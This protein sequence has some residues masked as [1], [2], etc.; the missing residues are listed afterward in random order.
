METLKIAFLILTALLSNCSSTTPSKVSP[1]DSV[2][3]GTWE[4]MVSDCIDPKTGSTPEYKDWDPNVHG[5]DRLR[6]KNGEV[7][8]ESDL[9]DKL[10]CVLVSND[11]W[12]I[13]KE[14]YR[15][16]SST[17]IQND[18]FKKLGSPNMVLSNLEYKYEVSED[19][20]RLYWDFARANKKL[21][22]AEKFQCAGIQI[23][24]YKRL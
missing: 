14:T 22:R 18:C 16:I 19:R 6:I 15:V 5:A 24:T 1:Y 21:V 20:L 11:Y 12:E 7:E 8:S 13:K 2:L 9:G 23:D 3:N 10:N 17:F 4:R